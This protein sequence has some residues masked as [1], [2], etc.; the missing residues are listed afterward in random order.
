[1][2]IQSSGSNRGLVKFN[3]SEIE[4]MVGS[5]TVLSA[6]LRLT[7]TDNGNNWGPTGRT[8]D[9]HRLL[10]DWA[11]GSGTEGDRGD[12]EGA[13][14]NCAIDNEILNQAKDCDG[15]TE[16]EMGQPNN[17]SVHPWFETATATQ[18]ITNNLSGVVEYDVTADILAFLSGDFDNYGWLIKKANEGQAGQ[19]S[20]G[21]REGSFVPELVITISGG[22]G[23]GGG[24]S[25]EN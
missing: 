24:G 17:P 7:I 5:G 19:V 13:T 14:W 21:T 25:G 9:I 10:S 22:S 2:H 11:E 8:V 23:Q 15:S 6:T 1:M 4:S 20:F 18:T 16:W 3:Q 12:G